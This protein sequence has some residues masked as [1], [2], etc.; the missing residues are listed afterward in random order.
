MNNLALATFPL[1]FPPPLQ[2]KILSCIQGSLFELAC[3]AIGVLGPFGSFA[4]AT[5]SLGPLLY[6]HT[7]PNSLS[8]FLPRDLFLESS[9]ASFVDWVY[10]TQGGNWFVCVCEFVSSLSHPLTNPR[11]FV[12]IGPTNVDRSTSGRVCN[13][14]NFDPSKKFLKLK[15]IALFSNP[16]WIFFRD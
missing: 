2:T 10:H 11:E 7:S 12:K 15:T 1:G 4:F 6:L 8:T 16:T 14:P 13:S 9:L 5:L 3:Y